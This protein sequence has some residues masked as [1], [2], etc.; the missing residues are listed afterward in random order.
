MGV[1]I[2]HTERRHRSRGKGWRPRASVLDGVVPARA[3]NAD[4]IPQAESRTRPEC[5]RAEQTYKM[6]GTCWWRNNGDGPPS[7][8]GLRISRL[9][10]SAA[11]YP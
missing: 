5:V 8:G 2:Y 6:A 10:L 9:R 4:A 7:A 11:C 1:T 3:I